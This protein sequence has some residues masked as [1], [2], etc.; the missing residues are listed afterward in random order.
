[1]QRSRVRLPSAPL[2]LNL[3]ESKSFC[4]R[5]AAR[6]FR[7]AQSGIYRLAGSK[8]ERTASCRSLFERLRS[9]ALAVLLNLSAE[10]NS[11]QQHS[12]RLQD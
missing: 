12:K 5:S 1:M 9:S 2:S 3:A 11:E 8:R 10:P 4:R 7:E 6:R